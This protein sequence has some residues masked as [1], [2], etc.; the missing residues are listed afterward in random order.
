MTKEIKVTE[1]H[2]EREKL[3]NLAD[4]CNLDY[5]IILG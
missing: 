5:I 3:G 4:G 1:E 2:R